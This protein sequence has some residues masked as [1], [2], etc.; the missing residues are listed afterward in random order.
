MHELEKKFVCDTTEIF[1]LNAG[2]SSR[3]EERFSLTGSVTDRTLLTGE[4]RGCSQEESKQAHR[5][6]SSSKAS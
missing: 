4:I 2:T 3:Y 6:E 5:K 1:Y